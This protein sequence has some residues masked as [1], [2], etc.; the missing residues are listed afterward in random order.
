MT[1]TDTTTGL[2]IQTDEPATAKRL[3]AAFAAFDNGDLEALQKEIAADATWTNA[4]SGPIAGEHR[5][6]DQ[7]VQMLGKLVEISDG[8]FKTKIVSILANDTQAAAVYDATATVNG[9][10]ATHRFFLIDDYDADGKVKSTNV[11][12]YDQTS[13]DALMRG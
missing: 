11:V 1:T 5:G 4:G 3:R 10:T 8:T 7:I 13:A 9:K 2:S 6:W 12:A